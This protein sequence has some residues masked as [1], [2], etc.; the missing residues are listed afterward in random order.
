M[1][2]VSLVGR[3]S[4]RRDVPRGASWRGPRLGPPKGAEFPEEEQPG[5]PRK[6]RAVSAPCEGLSAACESVWFRVGEGWGRRRLNYAS[7]PVHN[8][9]ILLVSSNFR[10]TWAGAE[11]EVDGPSSRL[12]TGRAAPNQNN[13]MFA[14]QCTPPHHT[15]KRNLGISPSNSP[16]N[17]RHRTPG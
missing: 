12:E 11:V 9:C 14:L 10:L 2:P 13:P 8:P 17:S 1:A 6:A 4:G 7:S 3:N 15:S 16:I 5:T